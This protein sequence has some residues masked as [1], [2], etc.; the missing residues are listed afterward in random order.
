LISWNDSGCN[1]MQTNN[2]LYGAKGL[3]RIGSDHCLTISDS[4]EGVELGLDIS[5]LKIAGSL[6]QDSKKR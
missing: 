2:A 5:S 3:T 4:G 6:R 1:P